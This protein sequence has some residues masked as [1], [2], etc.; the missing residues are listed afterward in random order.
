MAASE[1]ESEHS[2]TPSRAEPRRRGRWAVVVAGD[3]QSY[4]ATDLSRGGLFLAG[5]VGLAPGTVVRVE[6]ALPD[7]PLTLEAEVRWVR[8]RR[9]SAAL[10]QGAGLAFR[11][12]TPED[13]QRL[14]AALA[15][16]GGTA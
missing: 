11:S 1:D 14:E 7:G 13:Q 3:P 10:P 4:V 2:I 8:T 9:V 16:A 5:T 12:A 15:A 6:I